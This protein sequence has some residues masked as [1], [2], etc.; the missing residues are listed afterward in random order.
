[1][2]TVLIIDDDRHIV[3]TMKLVLESE[4]HEVR[5]AFSGAEGLAKTKETKQ[6][7]LI[8]DVMM[9]TND[10]GFEVARELKADADHKHIPILMLTAVEKETGLEFKKHAG[11]KEWLPVDDFCDKSIKPQELIK[12]VEHLLNK[13]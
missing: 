1:M 13:K 3:E 10:K 11:D 2:A 5:T 7:L 9:E 4:G 8:V 6:D 12:K